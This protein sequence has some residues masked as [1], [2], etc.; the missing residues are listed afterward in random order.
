MTDT[1]AR[2][3]A[4]PLRYAEPNNNGKV[5]CV[6]LVRL[7]TTGG[8]VGWGEA[9][10]GAEDASLAVKVIVDRGVGPRLLGRDPRAVEATWA[11]LRESTYWSGN[12]GIVTFALSAIDMAMWDLAG[13]LAGLPVYALL[14]GKQRDRV[15]AASSIIFDTADIPGIGRQFADLRARGYEVLKGGWGHD[16]SIAF[17]RDARRDIEIV[18]TVRE[19]VGDE[20]E[21]IVDVVAGSGWTASH[22]ITMARAFEPYR[23]YWLEDALPESDDAGWARLRAATATPLCTGEKGWTVGHFRGLIDRGALDIVMLDPG[24]AEGVTGSKKVIDRA[25]ESRMAWNA[26]TWSSALNTAASLHLAAASPNVLVLELKPEPGP[27]QHEL[28]TDPIEM[29]DG[30]VAVR[31]APG[32]GVT[33][34][35]AVVR[36]YTFD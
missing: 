23:L 27:M 17:G 36:R 9:I 5:R 33:V 28:V 26:H 13:R 4:F 7:E 3:E 30:Y 34:D 31:D 11:E 22:A 16:L 8:A 15:R 10:T 21:I 14:G 18:R 20:A 1:I 25:A 35:E 32:L 12:G 6:T 29:R 24:R 19:A 2:V